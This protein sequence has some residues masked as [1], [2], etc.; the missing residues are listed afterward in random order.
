MSQHTPRR[1][2]G[3]G[4]GSLF[5]TTSSSQDHQGSSGDTQSTGDLASTPP[6]ESSGGTATDEKTPDEGAVADGEDSDA[7]LAPVQGAWFAELPIARI[8]PNPRQPRQTFDEEAMA[9]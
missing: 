7:G 8:V 5:P 1:G 4:L 6:R 2:L 3:R 9:E